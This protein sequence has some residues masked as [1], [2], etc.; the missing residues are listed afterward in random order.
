M[1]SQPGGVALGAD[2]VPVAAVEVDLVAA[3][4][5]RGVVADVGVQRVAVV[6]RLRV[7][8]GSLDRAELAGRHARPGRGGADDGRPVGGTGPGAPGGGPAVGR[9]PVQR[10]AL[11]A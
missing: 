2:F 8:A 6:G 4:L 1:K 3:G 11:V 10:E 5:A 7:A 9:E